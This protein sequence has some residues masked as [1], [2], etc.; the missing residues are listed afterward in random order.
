MM[1]YTECDDIRCKN[2]SLIELYTLFKFD[3]LSLVPSSYVC[4]RT[5]I[6]GAFVLHSLRFNGSK[7]FPDLII[8]FPYFIY[9][10]NFCFD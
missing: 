7:H 3:F 8:I 6:T 1:K 2:N 10:C 9:E 5:V 4:S